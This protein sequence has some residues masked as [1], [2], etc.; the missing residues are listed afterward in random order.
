[1]VRDKC[2]L[3][4][5]EKQLSFSLCEYFRDPFDNITAPQGADIHALY[6]LAL[7]IYS[8]IPSLIN[9]DIIKYEQT[10]GFVAISLATTN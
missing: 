1:M 4:V 7:P 3:K 8:I 10:A 5:Q 6:T 9:T 2:N